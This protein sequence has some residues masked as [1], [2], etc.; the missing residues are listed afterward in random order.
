MIG[1]DIVFNNFGISY[2]RHQVAKYGMLSKIAKFLVNPIADNEYVI[3]FLYHHKDDIV[4]VL[5]HGFRLL[6][7]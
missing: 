7:S 5:K 3:C 1:F 2:R 4:I 6:R